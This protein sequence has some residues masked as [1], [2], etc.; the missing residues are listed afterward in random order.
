MKILKKILILIIRNFLRFSPAIYLFAFYTSHFLT[1]FESKRRNKNQ[2]NQ[3]KFFALSHWRFSSDI[4]SLNKY[5]N[6]DF[7]CLKSKFQIMINALWLNY[8]M[9]K[10]K[11]NFQDE[12]FNKN[13][14]KM[15]LARK[16]LQIFLGKFIKYLFDINNFKAAISC[17]FYFVENKDWENA[18]YKKK[19][20]FYI[21]FREN[22]LDDEV[23]SLEINRL[24]NLRKKNNEKYN[25]LGNKVFV[26]NKIIIKILTQS[27]IV[28]NNKIDLIG[29]PRLDSF[30]NSRKNKIKTDNQVLL[31]SPLLTLGRS[32]MGKFTGDNRRKIFTLDFMNDKDIIFRN[33]FKSIHLYLTEYAIK[34]PKIKIIF[35][36][37]FGGIPK[38]IIYNIIKKELNVDIRKIKNLKVIGK[39]PTLNLIKNSDVVIGCSST[40]LIEA[41]ILDKHVICPIIEEAK[42]KNNKKFI[43]FKKYFHLF[44]IIYSKKELNNLLD[45]IFQKKI[46]K[47]NS[48]LNNFFKNYLGIYDGSSSKTMIK[49]INNEI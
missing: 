7:Y 13:N 23:V 40:G 44:H 18:F 21:I 16:E 37:K 12:F 5:A 36:T 15:Q 41:K 49:K 26:S 32:N 47:K 39:S 33:Y 3:N 19:I 28:P 22:M 29:I 30:F 42:K 2:K 34:N 20:P 35:K 1:K 27:G 8:F 14:K 10:Y 38:R 6:M 43:F 11:K 25:F 17:S 45:K 48:N 46:N 31:L 9:K 4:K 24:R